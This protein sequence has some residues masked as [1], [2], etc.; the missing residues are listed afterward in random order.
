MSGCGGLTDAYADTI[1][2]NGGIVDASVTLGNHHT[3]G[4]D[5][6]AWDIAFTPNVKLVVES[7]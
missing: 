3:E 2:G 7:K 5:I 6:L 4:L 1:S